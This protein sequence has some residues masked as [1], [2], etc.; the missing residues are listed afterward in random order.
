MKIEVKEVKRSINFSD[1][2]AGELFCLDDEIYGI[3][4]DSDEEGCQAVDVRDG[5]MLF[6]AD[7]EQVTPLH[8]VLSVQPKAVEE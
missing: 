1:L 2:D 5:E 6:I 3:R 8:G 4:T 7:D